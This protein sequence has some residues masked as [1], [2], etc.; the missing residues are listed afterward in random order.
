MK[1]GRFP[2][3]QK[4]QI[5][6]K[7]YNG[8][9]NV[10]VVMGIFGFVSV[11]ISIYLRAALWYWKQENLF[12]CFFICKGAFCFFYLRNYPHVE[13]IWEAG[14]FYNLISGFSWLKFQSLFTNRGRWNRWW[15]FSIRRWRYMTYCI[16]CA[17]YTLTMASWKIQPRGE[18]G[19]S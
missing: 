19:K 16:D 7:W 3:N 2:F 6:W 11:L 13:S 8:L 9:K 4:F 10:L 15:W 18:I 1:L 14:R 17:N 12:F 5:F